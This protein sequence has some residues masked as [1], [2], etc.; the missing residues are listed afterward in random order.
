M[1]TLIAMIIASINLVAISQSHYLG[2]KGGV[3][4]SNQS[5]DFFKKTESIQSISFGLD[6]GFKFK[7][8]LKIG[9]NILYSPTGFKIP[10][11]FTDEFGNPI[12]K[13]PAYSKL[14]YSYLSIPLKI[15]YEYG[16]K[17]FVYGNIGIATSFL[18]NAKTSSPA[19]NENFE[20]TGRIE[21]DVTDNVAPIEFGGIIDIGFGYTF[22]ERLGV[23]VEG[24]FHHGFTSIST[25]E[26]FAGRTILN[27]WVSANIG[28]RY[29]FNTQ[30][31]K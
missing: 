4:W 8:N 6:Y 10:L 29:S 12:D 28:I 15:G 25:N 21:Y 2:L 17:G 27:Y 30:N 3:N 5:G 24:N 20:E 13:D 23:Y 9:G 31:S 14:H 19:I 1:K 7:S 26:Y 16:N 18:L 22:F 11:K